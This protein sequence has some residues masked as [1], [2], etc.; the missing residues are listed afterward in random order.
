MNI[1]LTVGSE[2]V[3]VVMGGILD[4]LNRQVIF[5]WYSSH[6]KHLSGK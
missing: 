4:G 3:H 1:A 5:G 6:Q 2:F